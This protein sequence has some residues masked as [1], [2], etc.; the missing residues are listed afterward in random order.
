MSDSELETIWRDR[1]NSK[2][3]KS[4]IES[5]H[6]EILNRNLEL[7]STQSIP[8]QM[9]WTKVFGIGVALWAIYFGCRYWLIHAY[10]ASSWLTYFYQDVVLTGFRLPLFIAILV[11]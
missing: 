2:Y 7:S 11:L 6:Q 8:N 1:S 4:Y 3:S 9:E 5:V 10:P